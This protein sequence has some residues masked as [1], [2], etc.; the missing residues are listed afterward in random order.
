MNLL[1]LASF[2]ILCALS[3]NKG[4]SFSSKSYHVPTIIPQKV[5]VKKGNVFCKKCI[6]DLKLK[7]PVFI[8][9]R[10]KI[11]LLI[12]AILSSFH[13]KV[14][15]ASEL[16]SGAS[17]ISPVLV[18]T[19]VFPPVT[20]QMEFILASRL[21]FASITGS[22][23]GWERASKNHSAGVRTMALVSLG[24]AAFT[25]CSAYGFHGKVDPSR[26]A[27]N[28]ASGVGF[29]GAG[30][31]TT[32][33]RSQ[34][35]V[36]H[37][38]TTAAAIWLSAAIGVA[39]GL[40]LHVIS[41]AVALSTVSI[42]KLGKPNTDKDV[43]DQDRESIASSMLKSKNS[44]YYSQ[45][46]DISDWDDIESKNIVSKTMG[47]PTENNLSAIEFF[48]NQDPGEEKVMRSSSERKQE[49]KQTVYQDKVE[50]MSI[51]ENIENTYP[52]DP[53]NTDSGKRASLEVI[54]KKTITEESSLNP[55]DAIRFIPKQSTK[56]NE[57]IPLKGIHQEIMKPGMNASFAETEYGP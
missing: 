28:V 49:N 46:R 47:Q 4:T 55:L 53:H 25:M 26:M 44:N 35:E 27:A 22:I 54:E 5:A 40:G 24:A 3:I 57:L 12:G 6:S 13:G 8:G 32:E 21:L 50:V 14:A 37:G 1:S 33:A 48:P 34:S 15:W 38:L 19:Y 30:V 18:P 23:V 2:L 16:V 45:S 39:S 42:L 17:M 20:R 41:F 31:I 29:L 43:D 52:S 9:K 56:D 51:P 10:R 7:T 36:V 11:F